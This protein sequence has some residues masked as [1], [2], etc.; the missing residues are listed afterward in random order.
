MENYKF[1]YELSKK[2]LDEE[3]DRYKKLDEKAS[4]FLS[5][6]S[7]GIVAYTALINAASSKLQ[8]MSSLGVSGWVFVILTGLTFIALFSAWFRIFSSIKLSDSPTIAI[9]KTVN[10]LAENEELITMY[11]AMALSCQDALSLARP[12]LKA[13]TDYLESAYKEI[14]CATCLLGTCLLLYFWI[15]AFPHGVGP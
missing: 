7:I 3:L 8:M 4:R 13:K 9:G 15:T 6:L 5:I 11:N 12:V 10:E 14:F 1:L 2:A